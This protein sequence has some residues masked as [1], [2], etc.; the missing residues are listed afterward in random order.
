MILDENGNN[1]AFTELSLQG[2][3]TV[4]A[5]STVDLFCSTFSGIS[6]GTTGSPPKITAIKVDGVN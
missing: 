3:I 2:Y 1:G 4:T 5:D 6:G